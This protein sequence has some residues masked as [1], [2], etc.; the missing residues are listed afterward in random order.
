MAALKLVTLNCHGL[1][2]QAKRDQLADFFTLVPFDIIFLQ[3]THVTDWA[4][5][6][7]L[8]RRYDCLGH[9]S[10]GTP[11]SC[12]VGILFRTRLSVTDLASGH[13]HHGRLVWVDFELQSQRFRFIN[14]YAPNEGH[15]RVLFF[16]YVY[17]PLHS[18]RMSVL[19]G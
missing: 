16:G 8:A 9:W 10:F 4:D 7:A 13:D 15:D 19:G 17:T 11:H 12:G 14:V 1:R 2:D 3:E 5:G 6:D 18:N